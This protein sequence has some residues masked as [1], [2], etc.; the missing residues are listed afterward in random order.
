MNTD[1]PK[2]NTQTPLTQAPESKKPAAKTKI[3]KKKKIPNTIVIERG[4]FVI[5]FK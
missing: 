1:A 3:I 4:N 2:N 5:S